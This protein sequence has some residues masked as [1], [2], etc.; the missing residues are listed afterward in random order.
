MI[1]RVPRK[2]YQDLERVKHIMETEEYMNGWGKNDDLYTVRPGK[3][4]ARRVECPASHWD[5]GFNLLIGEMPF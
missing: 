1:G 2:G 3:G 5:T 4:K